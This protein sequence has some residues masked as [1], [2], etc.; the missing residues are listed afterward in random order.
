MKKFF[1][2]LFSFIVLAHIQTFAAETS[3]S[4][5]RDDLK[6]D[7]KPQV[8]QKS[9]LQKN[10]NNTISELGETAVKKIDINEKVLNYKNE[11][12]RRNR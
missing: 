7:T 10:E 4:F 6:F 12:K 11:F 8:M 5:I 2:I 3:S 9:T 1:G